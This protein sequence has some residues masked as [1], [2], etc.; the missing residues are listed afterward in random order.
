M[1]DA[2]P[3]VWAGVVGFLSSGECARLS[4]TC[5]CL[6]AATIGRI[7]HPAEPHLRDDVKTR[8]LLRHCSE[9]LPPHPPPSILSNYLAFVS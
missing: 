1:A 8:F 4:T 2:P 9:L 5:Y 6:A 7:Y 3:E